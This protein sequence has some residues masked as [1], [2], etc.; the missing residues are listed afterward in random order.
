VTDP[1]RP[2]EPAASPAPSEPP[3]S[4]EPLGPGSA[5][6]AVPAEPFAVLMPLWAKDR[7]ERVE[8]AI[9]SATTAQQLPPS[10]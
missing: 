9:V 8:Q 5:E 1:S 3:G 10:C 4:A 6:P 7:P 2:V